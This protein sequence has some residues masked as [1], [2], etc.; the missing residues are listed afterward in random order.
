VNDDP[1]AQLVRAMFSRAGDRS[2][3]VAWNDGRDSMEGTTGNGATTFSL[4]PGSRATIAVGVPVP[5]EVRL[6][7]AVYRRFD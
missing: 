5:E 1:A 4:R 3:R 6:G 2:V 7:Y